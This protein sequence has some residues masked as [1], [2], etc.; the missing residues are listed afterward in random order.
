[1]GVYLRLKTSKR[2]ESNAVK[3][4]RCFKEVM[5]SHGTFERA[6]VLCAIPISVHTV[7]K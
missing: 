5:K 2:E 7:V 6:V 1:M 3:G 4:R